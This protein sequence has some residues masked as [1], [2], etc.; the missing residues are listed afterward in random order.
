M[1]T[2]G[3]VL[4]FALLMSLLTTTARG[5]EPNPELERA[6]ALVAVELAKLKLRQPTAPVLP[7]DS[8]QPAPAGY[9]WIKR[10][11]AP[12]KLEPIAPAVAAPK[13]STFPTAGCGCTANANCGASFC[14]SRGGT[15]CPQSCPVKQK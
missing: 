15:G 8:S 14:K 4:L 9:Q 7:T 3:Y 5:A 2:L 6:R 10:G 12:W 13:G 1:K 11:D